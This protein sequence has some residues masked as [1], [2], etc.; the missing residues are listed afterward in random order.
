MGYQYVIEYKQGTENPAANS[1]LRR[2]KVH[3]MA[4]LMLQ[5]DW[6]TQL[7]TEVATNPFFQKLD[8]NHPHLVKRDGI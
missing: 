1:L 2:G 5:A 8:N 4:M 6:W 3:F 7:Q